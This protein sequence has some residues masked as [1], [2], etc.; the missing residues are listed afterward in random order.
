MPD[1]FLVGGG[2][3]VM[4]GSNDD[5]DSSGDCFPSLLVMDEAERGWSE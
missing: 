2:A 5:P 4:P 3:N 1:S